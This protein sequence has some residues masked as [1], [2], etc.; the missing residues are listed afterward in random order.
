MA[1]VAGSACM[2]SNEQERQTVRPSHGASSNRLSN[3]T[4][5]ALFSSLF[6]VSRLVACSNMFYWFHSSTC[7]FKKTAVVM[8][9][10]VV[11]I[12]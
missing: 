1:D 11:V 3:A 5:Q 9:V 6:F 10:V 2:T 4:A 12:F 8:V 7:W